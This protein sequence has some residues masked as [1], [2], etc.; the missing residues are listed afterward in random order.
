MRSNVGACERNSKI[1]V[2]VRG[3]RC[4]EREGEVE[5]E[6]VRAEPLNKVPFAWG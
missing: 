4:V 3:M 6:R 5:G 1:D 2:R